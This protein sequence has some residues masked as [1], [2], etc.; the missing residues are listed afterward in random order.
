MKVYELTGIEL[1]RGGFR[2]CIDKL[3]FEQGRIH[4]IAGPN[5]SG[6][7]TLLNL[8][9]FLSGPWRGRLDFRGN[10][11]VP[12]E[13][14]A[15]PARRRQIGYL[16][17]NPY[18]FNTTVRNNIRYGLD[19]RG[20]TGQSAEQRVRQVA[21]ELNLPEL[22]SADAHRLSGGEAQRVALARTLAFKPDVLLLDEPTANVDR[23]NIRAIEQLVKTLNRTCGT[24]VIMS[25]HSSDQA[26]RMTDSMISMV[27]GKIA[28]AGYEN[29]FSGTLRLGNNAVKTVSLDQGPRIH[30]ASG[31]EGPVT[32]VI[33]PAEIILSRKELQSSALNRLH[34][35]ITKTEDVNGSVRVLID[36]GILLC[37]L[38]TRRSYADLGLNIGKE[39]WATFKANAVRVL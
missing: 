35:P 12:S 28:H 36:C 21:E 14:T 5:G 26:Y 24:S 34:G 4:A 8:M 11:V 20:I 19:V 15:L 22:L 13:Q 33:D 39:V 3:H 6:K 23:Q 9:G 27:D 38:V 31:T 7:T 29:V 2:L 17:Q 10:T 18:L 37:A 30:V 32:V 16:M 25:T 1:Q